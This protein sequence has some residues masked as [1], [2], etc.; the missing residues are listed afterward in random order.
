MHMFMN[1]VPSHRTKPYVGYPVTSWEE[2]SAVCCVQS[3]LPMTTSVDS[4]LLYFFPRSSQ[5]GLNLLQWP[6]LKE[7]DEHF[8]RKIHTHKIKH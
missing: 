2:Q 3:T 7:Q 8:V 4:W 5:V 1:I 6:H